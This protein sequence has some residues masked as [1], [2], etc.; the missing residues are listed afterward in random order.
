MNRSFRKLVQQY[1][2]QFWILGAKAPHIFLRVV[3][4]WNLLKTNN[5]VLNK[6]QKILWDFNLPHNYPN[7]T[8]AK[9]PDRLWTLLWI[10]VIQ[11][12]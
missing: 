9:Y 2:E 11:R 4:P 7:L 12:H 5:L 1:V 10:F 6:G 8:I 3:K